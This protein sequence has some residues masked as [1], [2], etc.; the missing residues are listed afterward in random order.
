MGSM[1]L[2]GFDGFNRFDGFDGLVWVRRMSQVSE[3]IRVE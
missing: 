1:D 3:L 2:P